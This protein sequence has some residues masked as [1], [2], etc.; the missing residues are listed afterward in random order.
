MHVMKNRFRPNLFD[1]YVFNLQ[2][3]LV[4]GFVTVFVV[5]S[6]N[7]ICTRTEKLMVA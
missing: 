5:K 2:D 7:V 6:L 1:D 4:F 3:G